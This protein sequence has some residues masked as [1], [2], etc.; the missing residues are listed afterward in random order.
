MGKVYDIANDGTIF[1]IRDD[2]S[3]SRLAKID[4]RGNV[5]NLTGK[6]SV[7]N[8]KTKL[9][10]VLS[11]VFFVISVVSAFM[12]Y[13]LYDEWS[14]ANGMFWDELE[15]NEKLDSFIDEIAAEYPIIITDI[16]I[17][18]TYNGGDI[19]T[20]YGERIYDYNTMY[21]KPKVYYKGLAYGEKTF[22]VKL[23]RPNGSLST[24]SS[25]PYGF[26]YSDD[27]NIT[28]SDGVHSFTLSGWGNSNKGHWN[29]GTYRIEVW[30]E[31]SCLKSKTFRI[32]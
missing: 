13:E 19:Q 29:S 18:N 16:K 20:D 2:G 22:K 8:G 15:E 31:N 25:S 9:W 1:K 11:I 7:R 32:H 30:Y 4:D 12:I 5:T 10:I 3:I 24:G 27:A 26:T 17:A 14:A 21:L 6:G 23:Y 28:D